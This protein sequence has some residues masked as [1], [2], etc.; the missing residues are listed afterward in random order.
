VKVRQATIEDAAAIATLSAQLG[1][2]VAATTMRE[3]LATVL[4]RSDETVLVAHVSGLVIGWIHGAEQ[5]FLEAEARCEL[6]GL[7]VSQD[8]RRQGVGQQLVRAVEWWARNRGI[9]EVSVRSN[10]VRPESHPFYER[11][12]YDRIKT[13]HV[14]RKKL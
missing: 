11:L 13:Q 14:Y 10:V 3:R 6:L 7:V 2:P 5:R 1:Y 12:G 8:H 9:T 4:G